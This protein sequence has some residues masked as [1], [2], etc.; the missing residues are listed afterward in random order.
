MTVDDAKCRLRRR[1]LE[2]RRAAFRQRGR[3]AA[4]ALA[5]H[6]LEV[7]G[8]D[9]RGGGIAAPAGAVVA[10]Y[11]PKGDELD[12]G[13]LLEALD[14]AGYA[15]ALPVVVGA[16][17]ILAFRRWRPAEALAPGRFG[18]MEPVAGAADLTP[19]VVITP[20]LAFDPAG[21]R[22]GYGAGYYDRTLR[23]LRA[24]APVV[25]V[26][27]GFAAQGVDRVPH[28]ATDERLDWVITEAG[29]VR[30]EA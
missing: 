7:L 30:I 5:G 8:L 14:A 9:V 29:A 26:G 22:L 15:C 13:P 17:K 4:A 10:G 1:M 18:I 27:A 21:Y 24:T 20:L 19:R 12:T 16:D 11:W 25:A 23:A 2:T 28:A 6:V 3:A